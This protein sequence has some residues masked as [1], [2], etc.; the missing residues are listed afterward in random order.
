MSRKGH[1]S[2]A[3]GQQF[4][5][6]ANF[7]FHCF[8]FVACFSVWWLYREE[9]SCERFA[10]GFLLVFGV[11]VRRYGC[12][13]AGWRVDCLSAY[14]CFQP[15]PTPH[16]LQHYKQF[17]TKLKINSFVNGKKCCPEAPLIFSLHFSLR[18]FPPRTSLS[19]KAQD[20]EN[21]I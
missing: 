1:T 2:S 3:A 5:K 21:S 19:N 6:F 13:R 14:K 11:F 9:S 7:I 18:I 10:G 16:R 17:S 4:D 20:G 8:S 12:S 15:P